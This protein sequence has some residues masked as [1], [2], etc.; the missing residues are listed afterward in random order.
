[1]RRMIRTSV[2]KSRLKSPVAKSSFAPYASCAS[3]SSPLMIQASFSRQGGSSFFSDITETT[4][5]QVSPTDDTIVVRSRRQ[6]WLLWFFYLIFLLLS[7]VNGQGGEIPQRSNFSSS[8]PDECAT[9]LPANAT[10]DQR[11]AFYCCWWALMKA[12]NGKCW[13]SN[14]TYTLVHVG[15]S[16]GESV[17]AALR[18]S[19]VRLHELHGQQVALRDE[20][21]Q[22]LPLIVLLR[23]P[24]RRTV[25]AFNWRHP[26]KG[27]AMARARS[28]T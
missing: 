21:R 8:F 27:G 16:A 7:V 1:M 20:A 24:L 18:A 15:K 13:T 17:V 6:G 23:S 14:N 9:V 2:G 12:E 3:Q 22:R 10:L 4:T 5:G 25:S 19:G 28:R 26:R 11:R